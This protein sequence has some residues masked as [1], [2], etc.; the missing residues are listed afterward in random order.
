ML[1]PFK[2]QNSSK[3]SIN[4]KASTSEFAENLDHIFLYIYTYT[5]CLQLSFTTLEIIQPIMSVLADAK[6]LKT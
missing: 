2:I 1:N 4:F 3:F 6:V 5:T